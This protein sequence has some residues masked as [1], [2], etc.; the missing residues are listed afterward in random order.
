MRATTLLCAIFALATAVGAASAQDVSYQIGVDLTSN[1]VVN[2]VSDSNDKA[3]IQPYFEVTVNGFYAGTWISTV[4][5]GTDDTE[6][7]FYAGYRTVLGKRVGI[8]VS[9]AQYLYNDTGSCCGEFI[10][11]LGYAPTDNFAIDLRTAYNPKSEFF[12]NRVTLGYA[13]TDNLGLSA[14]YGYKQSTGNKYGFV[15]ASYALN[16]IAS[17]RLRY[18]DASF[19]Y[20]GLVFALSLSNTQTSLRRL[21]LAPSVNR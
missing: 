7:D 20:Q 14:S 12:N 10:V 13:V 3:A 15:G 16:D 21:F 8:D 19:G 2:G 17:V 11:S 6:I 18:H 5:L 4:D 1:Y 9:Y